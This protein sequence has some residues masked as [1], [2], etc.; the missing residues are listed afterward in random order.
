MDGSRG[1]EKQIPFGNDRQKNKNK[2]ENS[3]GWA[4]SFPALDTMKLC[5]ERGTRWFVVD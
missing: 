3:G 5:L 2:S 1:T 4:W